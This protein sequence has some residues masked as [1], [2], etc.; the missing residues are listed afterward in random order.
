MTE[1]TKIICKATK[2]HQDLQSGHWSDRTKA[3]RLGMADVHKEI[4]DQIALQ[5]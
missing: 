4:D 2:N 3:Q 1:A 5:M